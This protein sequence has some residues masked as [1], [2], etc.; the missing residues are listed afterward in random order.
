MFAVYPGTNTTSGL[1]L[2][3]ARDEY[4]M[5]I[6]L[7]WL[8]NKILSEQSYQTRRLWDTKIGCSQLSRLVAAYLMLQ[9]QVVKDEMRGTTQTCTV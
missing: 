3:E 1:M 7:L 9:Q 4:L 6:E 5:N 8:R 2:I